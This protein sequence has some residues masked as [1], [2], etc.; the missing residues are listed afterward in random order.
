MDQIAGMVMP[1]LGKW[2]VA[3]G[4]AATPTLGDFLHW[5]PPCNSPNRF[6]MNDNGN[7]QVQWMV[8]PGKRRNLRDAAHKADRYCGFRVSRMILTTERG[9]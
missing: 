9:I 1:D 4:N 3:G 7:A 5:Q 8:C 6:R 2:A